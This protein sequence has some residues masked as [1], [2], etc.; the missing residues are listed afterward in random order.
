MLLRRR[1]TFAAELL[2]LSAWAALL[3]LLVAEALARAVPSATP[4]WWCTVGAMPGMASGSGAAGGQSVPAAIAAGMPMWALM[5]SAMMLPAALPAVRHVAVNS[6]CWRRGRAIAEFLAVYL[7][8]WVAYGVLALGALAWTGR[9]R[10]AIVLAF[11]LAVAAAWQLTDHKLRALRACHR[12]SPLPPRGWRASAGVAR[13][14]LRN[15]G[16]CL[17][18]CW[19]IMLVGALA[20]S[21]RLL[22]MLALTALV[23]A[24]KLSNRPLRATRRTAALLA[25]GAL[26]AGLLAVLA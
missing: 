1:P 24:E 6:L 17:G 20:T 11:A 12:S 8:I 2:L 26:G 3:A 16:A 14:G 19:A 15:G 9:V 22:W 5:S 18:S 4:L 21:G 10:S 7:A 23:C 25:G 13:F